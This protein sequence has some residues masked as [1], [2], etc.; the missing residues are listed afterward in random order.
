MLSIGYGHARIRNRRLNVGKGPDADLTRFSHGLTGLV[1]R[2]VSNVDD[3]VKNHE[4]NY[5]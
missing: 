2:R 1:K 4:F 5:R 3:L